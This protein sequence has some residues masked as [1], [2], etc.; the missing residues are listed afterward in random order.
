MA[1]KQ[2]KGGR[3]ACGKRGR[4]RLT[5]AQYGR[6]FLAPAVVALLMLTVFP[7]VYSLVISL[8]GWDLLDKG[9]FQF[10]GL[11][12]YLSVVRDAVYRKALAVTFAFTGISVALEVVLGIALAMLAYQNVFGTRVLRTVVISAMVISPVVVGTAWRLMYN[13]GYGLI[14]YILDRVGI[15]GYSF[16]A[17]AK[18][19]LG[20][21]IVTDVWEW[22]PLVFV[23]VLA[24]L[25]G[26]STDVLEA[27][28]V[29]GAG[30]WKRFTR[31]ILPSI[32]PSVVF[33]VLLRVMESFKSYDLIYTMTGGGPGTASQNLN[34][35]MYKTAFQYYEI[36]RAAAMAILSLLLVNLISAVLLRWNQSVAKE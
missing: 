6:L 34:V 24:A 4:L 26:V 16:L 9:S 19:V 21:I 12:N 20:A 15:G 7:M 8:F 22:T 5:D 2:M 11:K 25:Q 31:V 18:T 36:S 27:A 1:L 30:A 17:D 29:D 28:S 3:P 32:G 14:N 23:I 35:L 13:E 10:V 33:A